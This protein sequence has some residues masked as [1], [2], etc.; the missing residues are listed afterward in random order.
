MKLLGGSPDLIE[1]LSGFRRMGYD[2]IKLSVPLVRGGVESLDDAT[3]LVR[4]V[5]PLI[6][7]VVFRPMYPATPRRDLLAAD[8]EDAWQ[9]Q[10]ALR[11]LESVVEC[12]VEFD[13]EGCFRSAQ[14]ILAADGSLYSDWSL[15]QLLL[16]S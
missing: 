1:Q 10:T 6:D 7:S 8:I 9:W 5:S 4:R 12:K 11:D 15:R 13:A 3:E 2:R 14:L 16:V